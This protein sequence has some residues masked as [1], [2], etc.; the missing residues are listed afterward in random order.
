M[1]LP[2]VYIMASKKTGFYIQ[3]SPLK[4]I[5]LIEAMNLEWKDLYPR[6]I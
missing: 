1:K 3:A 4:K 2:C 5:A 6:I